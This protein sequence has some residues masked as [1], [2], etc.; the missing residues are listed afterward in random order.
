MKTSV[1]SASAGGTVTNVAHR[2]IVQLDRGLEGR[3]PA[4]VLVFASA[5]QPIRDILTELSKNY[6]DA[7][8]LGTSTAG[9]FT[10]GGDAKNS[11]TAVAIA[12]DFEVFTGF[13]AGLKSDPTAAIS[14]AIKDFPAHRDGYAHRTAILL[15]DPLSGKGE[16]ATLIAA[17]MLGE[18]VQLV[19]GAAGDDLSMKQTHV[20]LG[21]RVQSDAVAMAMIFSKSPWGVGVRHGHQPISDPLKITKATD[22]VV[23]EIDGR[24]AWEVWAEKTKTAAAA[25]NLDPN[26]LSDAEVGPYLLRYEAGLPTGG[27]LLKIR[28][29]LARGDDGSLSFACGMVEG[30]EVRITESV[31]QRQIESARLAARTAVEKLGAQPAAG[32][33]VF[34][35]ICRNL[36]LNDQFKDALHAIHE[37]IGK[38]PLAGFETYGEI[39]LNVG[40]MSGFHNTTTVVLAVPQ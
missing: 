3:P 30:A 32:A 1:A 39:A 27:E 28:A 13:G 21:P 31:P 38:T 9:E 24:P 4:L 18:E 14:A 17:S 22:N 26:S 15:L 34:D 7:A 5:S 10:E 37:E 20:G 33:I 36:I 40:D 16:E 2:L 11:T 19:G 35:C 29:P 8:V 23:Y 12:G 25:A 6:A